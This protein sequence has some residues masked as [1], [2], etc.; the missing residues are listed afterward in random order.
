MKKTTIRDIAK[1]SGVGVGTVS[2]VLNNNKSVA[3]ET[4][5]RVVEVMRQMEYQPSAT[6]VRLARRS[7]NAP[8]IG[9]LLPD[10]G[11]QFF[12]EIFGEIYRELREVGIDILIFNYEEHH[13]EVIRKI[14]DSAISILL[15]FN[16]H[17]D[18]EERELLI[19]RNIQY[20]YVDS[21]VLCERCIYTDNKH[22]GTL[23][24]NYLLS[25]GVK[26]PCFIADINNSSSSYDRYEGLSS[27][28]KEIG[29]AEIPIYYSK[30]SETE[31]KN[32]GRVIVEENKHDGIFC[33]CD[34][35][36]SGVIY[37]LREAQSMAQLIGFDGLQVSRH[38][39][40]PTISQH[41]RKIGLI[42]ADLV[43][44]M[45]SKEISM[46]DSIVTKIEPELVV[47]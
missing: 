46:D 16:F 36:A 17:L 14:L 27:A 24:G 1:K 39:K 21:P 34:E 18:D 35:I 9:I 7:K 32:L 5:E 13:V 42:A 25:K 8:T 41:P 31:G 43:K 33:F 10:I 26:N 2:R 19:G 30:L 28:Y 45:I 40:F 11:N 29:V 4:R 23:A 3:K 15:I 20:L 22:G 12:F 47:H 6:A 44:R 38:L 37:A